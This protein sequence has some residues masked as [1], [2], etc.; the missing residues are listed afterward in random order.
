MWALVVDDELVSRKKLQS[1]LS[2]YGRCD[3][4]SN[5]QEALDMI[6]ATIEDR[7]YYDLVTIDVSMPVMDG[8]ELLRQIRISQQTDPNFRILPT[9]FI[10]I[11][12]HAERNLVVECIQSGC[13]DY[14]I[15]PFKQEEIYK[16][17]RIMG[18]ISS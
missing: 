10:M 13:D 15:K 7:I 1:I 9:K 3:C 8:M 11:S 6:H 17:L 14:L 16:K 2:K 5:G 18:L 4:A 12:A